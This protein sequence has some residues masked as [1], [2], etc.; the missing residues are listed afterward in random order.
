MINEKEIRKFFPEEM[1]ERME[2]AGLRPY[3]MGYL[4]QCKP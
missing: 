1:R 4:C 3:H 2:D